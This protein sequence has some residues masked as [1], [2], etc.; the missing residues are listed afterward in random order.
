MSV[1]SFDIDRSH[2]VGALN[3]THE[4]TIYYDPDTKEWLGTEINSDGWVD[5][6]DE[7][8]YKIVKE[9][10]LYEKI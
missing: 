9:H 7:A 5:L 10:K 2:K 6:D 4:A 8:V 1:M 3:F